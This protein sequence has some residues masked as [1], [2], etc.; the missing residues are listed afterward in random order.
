M[1]SV[2]WAQQC[3]NTVQQNTQKYYYLNQHDKL[4]TPFKWLQ[5]EMVKVCLG[6]DGINLSLQIKK[7]SEFSNIYTANIPLDVCSNFKLCQVCNVG[8]TQSKKK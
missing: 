7:R 6:F 1:G 4:W 8:N 5:H 2:S 3:Q